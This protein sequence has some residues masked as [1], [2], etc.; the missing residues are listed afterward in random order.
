[1]PK[2]LGRYTSNKYSHPITTILSCAWSPYEVFCRSEL[3]TR[4]VLRSELEVTHVCSTITGS[5]YP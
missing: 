5:C 2:V 1:M 4:W 3:G